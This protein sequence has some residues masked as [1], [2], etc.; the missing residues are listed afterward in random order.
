M[1]PN[2][3]LSGSRCRS[4]SAFL[5]TLVILALG[6]AGPAKAAH[7]SYTQWIAANSCG[8]IDRNIKHLDPSER[9]YA[10]DLM[11]GSCKDAEAPASMPLSCFVSSNIDPKKC[12]H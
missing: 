1:T 11:R 8:S 4:R 6:T 3:L 10:Y 7:M 2:A 12:K 5:L 9:K